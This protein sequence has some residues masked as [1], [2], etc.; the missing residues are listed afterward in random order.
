MDATTEFPKLLDLAMAEIQTSTRELVERHN[1]AGYSGFEVDEPAGRLTFVD[2]GRRLSVPVQFL[3]YFHA[4]D[5]EWQWAWSDPSL[6]ES[7][8][9]AARAAREWGVANDIALLVRT[10]RGA[11]EE[12]CWKLAAFAAKLTGWPAIYRCPLANR[13]LFVAFGHPPP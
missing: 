7:I 11:V 2:G 5:A 6:S 8:T 1:L 13:F 12:G 10:H 9:R 4:D 3:G